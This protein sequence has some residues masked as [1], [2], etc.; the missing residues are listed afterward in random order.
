MTV[1]LFR[2]PVHLDR[3]EVPYKEYSGFRQIV[4]PDIEDLGPVRLL[5][6]SDCIEPEKGYEILRQERLDYGG[7]RSQ[8]EAPFPKE[9]HRDRHL[10]LMMVPPELMI[11]AY[12]MKHNRN[13]Y[14][15]TELTLVRSS[16]IPDYLW[17]RPKVLR[18]MI[19]ALYEGN[20]AFVD[21]VQNEWIL[22]HIR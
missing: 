17:A 16:V 7:I 4:P 8:P 9:K 13:I 18:K 3:R 14:L 5:Y 6:L 11:V 2:M 15:V 12:W 20:Q 1:T 19:A 22:K 21:R 10:E